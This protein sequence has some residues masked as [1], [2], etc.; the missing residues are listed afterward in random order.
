MT[1]ILL[2]GGC[3]GWLANRA[4]VQRDATAAIRQSGG[5]VVYDWQLTPVNYVYGHGFQPRVAGK[6]IW[7]KWLIDRLGPDYF[8]SVKQASLGSQATNAT[9]S[10]VGRLSQ[11]EELDATGGSKL[12]NAGLVHLQSLTR[13]RMVDLSLLPGVTGKGLIHLAELTSLERL[14]LSSPVADAD[15]VN[16]S[17]LTNLRLLRLNGGGNGITDEGLANLK[18]LTELRELILRNSQVTGTGL[19]ALQG[20]IAMADLKLI[21][22]HLETLE[23]LQRM[24]GLKSLWIHRSPLDD[25]GLKHVENLKSLQYLSLEDTRITD[26]GLKSL[27][28]LRGLREVDARGTGVTIMGS[29]TFQ[30]SNPK[31]S[32]FR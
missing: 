23:P 32:I 15:L 21:N 24:T 17:R 27:L 3:L 30:Q 12:T 10:H 29:A 14:N 25:R 5:T 18:G 7:P 20:M 19:T 16:L 1:L 6:S 28:D 22:S 8:G 4:N 31:T 11:L 13:L 2:L 26:D 9:M